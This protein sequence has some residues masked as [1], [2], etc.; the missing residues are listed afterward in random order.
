MAGDFSKK[1][2]HRHSNKNMQNQDNNYSLE[3][4]DNILNKLSENQLI[5]LNKKIIERIRILHKARQL[6]SMSKFHAGDVVYFMNNGRKM[7]GVIIRLNQRTVTVVVEG[8][9]QWNISPS[10]LGKN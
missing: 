10:L 7:S 2:I 9:A 3:Q 4:V 6:C 1:N 8:G 5:A